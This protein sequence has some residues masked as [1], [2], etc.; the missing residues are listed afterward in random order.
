MARKPREDNQQGTVDYSYTSHSS[1]TEMVDN[2]AELIDPAP[3]GGTAYEDRA[4]ML[5]E[6]PPIKQYRVLAD[7]LV[8]NRGARTLLRAGKIIDGANYDLEQLATQGVRYE[9]Y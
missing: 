8:M 2:S 3:M 7:A 4:A 5:A 9:E 1:A 6:V